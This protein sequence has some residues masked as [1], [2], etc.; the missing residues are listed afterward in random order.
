MIDKRDIYVL[1]AE[2]DS[3]SSKLI[4]DYLSAYGCTVHAVYD[5]LSAIEQINSS[6]F[7]I[8]ILDLRLPGQNGFVTA[9]QTRRI[10]N[11]NELPIIVTS[12]FTDQANKL[13]AYQAGA[14]FFLGK[15]IDLVELR[16]IIKN[17]IAK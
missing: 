10:K 1:L 16:M 6:D 14:N 4:V 3:N 5:G 17:I 2:D 13:K 12:A 11:S 15:P 9:E 7:D 8:M